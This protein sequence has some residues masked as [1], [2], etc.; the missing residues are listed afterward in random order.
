MSI[1]LSY[2]HSTITDRR[3]I[4]LLKE[5]RTKQRS[6]SQLTKIFSNMGLMFL[7]LSMLFA[8]V[9]QSLGNIDYCPDNKLRINEKIHQE[10]FIDYA[11]TPLGTYLLPVGSV[12]QVN[13]TVLPQSNSSV[14]FRYYYDEHNFTIWSPIPQNCILAPGEFFEGTFTLQTGLTSRLAEVG[15]QAA[16]TDG[17]TNATVHWWYEVLV[18]GKTPAAGFLVLSGTLILVSLGVVIHSKRKAIRNRN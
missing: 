1:F 11:Y 18:T 13:Y 5:K 12:I 4:I 7:I 6:K 10:S 15:F 9:S 2:T 17:I 3:K 16:V 8:N 14:S